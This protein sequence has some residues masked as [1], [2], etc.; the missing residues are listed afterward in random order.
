MKTIFKILIASVAGLGV[1]WL[2][3]QV[4]HLEQVITT[5]LA[6]ITATA[7]ASICDKIQRRGN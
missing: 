5:V 1:A 3:Y 2:C 6:V 4:F 7:T